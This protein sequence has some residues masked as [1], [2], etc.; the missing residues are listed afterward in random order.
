M[1]SS[2]PLPPVGGGGR[3]GIKAHPELSVEDAGPSIPS[4]EAMGGPRGGLL[5]PLEAPP[6]AARPSLASH[7]EH[8]SLLNPE[9]LL[10]LDD[11]MLRDE[12]PQAAIPR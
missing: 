12:A 7:V 5:P 10:A 3:A 4:L 2:K 8:A 11:E 6:T 1:V 9:D